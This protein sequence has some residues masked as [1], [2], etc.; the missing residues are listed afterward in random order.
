MK[1]KQ[2][3]NTANSTN[4]EEIF[5]QTNQGIA[6]FK[7]QK[8]A[9]DF[10]FVDIN[11]AGEQIKEVKKEA[12]LNRSVLD[13]FPGVK[14]FG[15]FKFLEDVNITGKPQHTLLTYFKE[16]NERQ[17]LEAGVF[18]LT[19][20]E[21]ILTFSDQT[22]IKNRELTGQQQL[23]DKENLLRDVHHQVGQSMQFLSQLFSLQEKR[24][25]DGADKYF[26]KMCQSQVETTAFIFKKLY[27]QTDLS[28]INCHDYLTDLT[29]YL[30]QTLQIEPNNIGVTLDIDLIWLNIETAIPLGIIVNKL[31]SNALL[32]AFPGRTSGK[33]TIQVRSLEEKFA[34]DPNLELLITDNGVGLPEGFVWNQSEHIGLQLVESVVKNDLDGKVRFWQEDGLKW[35]I[36]FRRL[37]LQGR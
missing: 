10:L 25:A 34:H 27:Q 8:D 6:V 21:L 29:H 9:S 23:A 4:F 15:L 32:F 33:I 28:R 16:N 18:K 30:W 26:L 7:A 1:K 37:D 12:I 36:Q 5:Q 13:V 14:S 3:P 31:V 17:Y 19:S 20:G 24:I 22:T 11:R 35:L 2:L